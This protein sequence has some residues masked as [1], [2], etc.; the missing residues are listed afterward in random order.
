M[1][2]AGA[3][4]LRAGEHQSVPFG[5]TVP[6]EAPITQVL[7]HPM[8]GVV[9]GVHT[10]VEVAGAMDKSDLDEVH[11]TALPVQQAILDAFVRLGFGFKGADL[12]RGHIAGTGQTLPFYQEIEFY[13][14]PQYAH[15]VSEV[16]VTFITDPHM[17]TVVIEFN[18]RGGQFTVG[19]DGVS[20]FTV[21]HA[22]AHLDWTTVVDGW[23]RQ[24]VERHQSS[25]ISHGSHHGGHGSLF[26]R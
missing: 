19:H 24:A 6:W 7:G 10:E 11:I 25:H 12:E 20:R 26:A 23:V 8:H 15:A 4:K 3:L 21:E 16:E 18:K 1:Q 2:V 9:V 17:V 13:P 5:V 14:A 22:A